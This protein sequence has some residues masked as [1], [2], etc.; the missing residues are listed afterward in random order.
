MVLSRATA[1]RL[2]ALLPL[3]LLLA[4]GTWLRSPAPPPDRSAAVRIERLDLQQQAVGELT[5]IA[6]WHLSSSN[7]HF[8]GYSA[9][10]ALRDHD[11]LS[12]SDRG[13]IM[14]LNLAGPAGPQADLGFL[15]G[16]YQPDKR[17]ID[18]ESMTRDPATGDLWIG[19][20]GVNAIERVDRNLRHPALVRP[21]RMHGWSA[22]TGPESLVRL[23]DGR[24]IVLSEGEP[25]WRWQD[26]SVPAL[27]FAHDPVAGG[28]P[29]AFRFAPPQGYRPVDMVQ[30][31]DGRVLVLLRR[32]EW[33]VPPRFT[34]KIMLLDPADI[35]AGHIWSGR[36]IAAITPPLPADNYEG[37]SYW[38]RDDGQLDLWLIS[39][40]NLASFQRTLLLQMRWNPQAEAAK[41]AKEKARSPATRPSNLNR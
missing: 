19:Y 34:S 4:P 11:F 6:G 21:A 37:L 35:S 12:A 13:R 23:A 32:W 31:P 40:D 15:S 8:G 41:Q 39:D 38:P 25:G 18:I 33:A 26:N 5:L 14:R 1:W 36:V 10:I 27:L 17:L 2:A 20:E 30:I 3:A 29:V 9:L 16:K 7:E 22:N 24:F 28:D